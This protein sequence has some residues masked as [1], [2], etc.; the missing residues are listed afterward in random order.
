M[1]PDQLTEADCFHVLPQ[2]PDQSVPVVL[3]DPPYPNG[4]ELFEETQVDGLAGLYLSCKK[5]SRH[6]I[7]FWKASDVPRP[8]HGWFETARHLWHKPDSTSR[9]PYE[10]VVVWSRERKYERCRVWTV[11]ILSLRSLGDWQHHHPTRKPVRLL[12]YLVELY[13]RPG[14]TVLDPFAGTGTTA[15]ACLQLGRHC[16]SI[17]QNPE[18]AKIARERIQKYTKT[19]PADVPLVA[20]EEPVIDDTDDDEPMEEL[21]PARGR[22]R[23]T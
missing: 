16:I 18:Y 21:E 3:T 8:P 9:T 6:V 14:E 20:F 17:E 15:V 22:K 7:F 5:A 23:R 19:E 2:I 11:P 13:T 1:T 10:A 12:R 4:K